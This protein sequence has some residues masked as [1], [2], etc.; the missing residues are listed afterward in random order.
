LHLFDLP[1]VNANPLPQ[2]RRTIAA[3]DISMLKDKQGDIYHNFKDFLC[4]DVKGAKMLTAPAGTGKTFL[5]GKLLEDYLYL[6]RGSQIALT[7]TTN[8]AVKVAYRMADYYH[9]NIHYATIHSLL[10]LKEQLNPRTGEMEFVQDRHKKPALDK[11]SVLIVDE[12]SMLPDELL[13]G[14]KN[15][16][17]I[18]DYVEEGLKVI[19]IGD[20]YQIPPV[21]RPFCALFSK[22][23]RLSLGIPAFT[24][25]EIVRQ[26]ADN[27]IIQI[28]TEVRTNLDQGWTF[29]KD[30]DMLV[31]GDKGVYF[32]DRYSDAK[33][34]ALHKTIEH[35][36]TSPNFKADPDFGKIIAYRNTVVG[37]MNN[38]VRKMI[39][40]QDDLPRV[41]V[42]DKLIVSEPIMRETLDQ[43]LIPNNEELE[44]L[45]AIER[46]ETIE[47]TDYRLPY[48][49]TIVQYRRMDNS[50]AKERIKIL[51]DDGF[52]V[53][54]ELCQKLSDRAKSFKRGTFSFSNA[55]QEYYAF[56]RIFASVAHNYA[57]TAHK[58]QGST[59]N[60]TIVMESDMLRNRNVSERNRIIYTSFTRP[61]ERLY[62]V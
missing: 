1:P 4:S 9:T 31:D 20:R 26:A 29:K 52:I 48:Y 14:S 51:T 2:K 58:A 42:G 8:K 40:Q 55:W 17:G 56:K 60:N 18:L 28:A 25:N 54:E 6:S 24:M 37:K 3:P 13:L 61:K 57:I 11:Y 19:F 16:K 41:L 21:G 33:M 47:G 49:Q 23:K 53:H 44:V 46:V 15:T 43:V 5:T 7:A 35:I 22:A 50:I 12:I 59:Y 27:P 10:G 34:D 38:M 45:E 39:F 30:E 62:I 36:F 32:V